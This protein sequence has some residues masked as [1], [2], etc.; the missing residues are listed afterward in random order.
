MTRLH[1]ALLVQKYT[2]RAV[3]NKSEHGCL[4]AHDLVL[5]HCS[6]SRNDTKQ[7]MAINRD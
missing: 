6:A 4:P 7:I 1:C 2:R 3:Y 5:P